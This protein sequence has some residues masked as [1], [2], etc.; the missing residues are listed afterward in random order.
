MF[1][2]VSRCRMLKEP[3]ANSAPWVVRSACRQ[4]A[5]GEKGCGLGG[6]ETG[7]TLDTVVLLIV[8]QS[9]DEERRFVH[10]LPSLSTV[11]SRKRLPLNRCC[12]RVQK[13]DFWSS[14]NIDSE[15][16]LVSFR[17]AHSR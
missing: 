2:V 11:L 1:Q 7:V 4:E 13:G 5:L 8:V 12:S 10:H 17:K 15:P 3:A 6:D 16:D 14:A 9:L